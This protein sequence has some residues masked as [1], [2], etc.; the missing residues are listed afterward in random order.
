MIGGRMTASGTLAELR[1][2]AGKGQ[3]QLEDVFLSLTGGAEYA[4]LLKHL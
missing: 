1:A 2:R 3:A 4:A